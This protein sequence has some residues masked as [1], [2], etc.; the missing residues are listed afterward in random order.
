MR[1]PFFSIACLSLAT[2][3]TA[4][5]LLLSLSSVALGDAVPRLPSSR[6][7]RAANRLIT[8]EAVGAARLGMTVAAARKAL[9]GH[10]LKR[11]ADAEGVALI[12]VL[13]GKKTVM[14]LYAGEED[15]AAPIREKAVIELIE[16][17][18]ARYATRAG[19]HPGML[20]T[21]VERH[22][23]KVK[24]ITKSEIESR[25]YAEFRASPPGM[26]FRVQGKSGAEAGV[27]KGT[28]ATTYTPTTY[29][30]SVSI[31]KRR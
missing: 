25:E 8:A 16:V 30:Y 6:A 31:R 9:K 19:V 24:R 22:Y 26:D 23:G 20:L 13:N 7:A 12:A 29:L 14:T 5:T 18:D 1:K 15:P 10:I 4:V 2:T 21:E 28:V 3:T 11:A 17:T 27:Y